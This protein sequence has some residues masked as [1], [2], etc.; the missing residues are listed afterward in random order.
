M[1]TSSEQPAEAIYSGGFVAGLLTARYYALRHS[2]NGEVFSDAAPKEIPP[3]V[4][5]ILERLSRTT[6]DHYI[7]ETSWRSLDH[8]LLCHTPEELEAALATTPGLLFH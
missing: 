4:F 2:L 6:V 3:V 7:F 5:G 1:T 8:L